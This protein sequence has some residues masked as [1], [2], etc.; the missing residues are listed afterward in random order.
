MGADSITLERG[1]KLATV[2][3]MLQEAARHA[4]VRIRPSGTDDRQHVLVWN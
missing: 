3:R 2:K 1:E 4:N